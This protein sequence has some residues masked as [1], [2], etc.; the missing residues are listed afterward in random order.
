MTENKKIINEILEVISGF[1][2]GKY[3][4]ITQTTND[5]TLNAIIE[6]INNTGKVLK[7]L[8][9]NSPIGITETDSKGRLIKIN[10]AFANML[11]YSTSE[12]I[13]LD[14]SD[15]THPDDINKTNHFINNLSIEN[16]SPQKI[17]S[18]YLHKTGKIIWGT[19]TTQKIQITENKE[20]HYFMAVEEI[21]N[22]REKDD[23]LKMAEEQL[24]NS[25]V[26]R[27]IL[28]NAPSMI[29]V[30]DFNDNLNFTLLNK[31]GENLLG[32]KEIEILGK[33]NYDLY[34]KDDADYL[35]SQD[36]KV[37]KTK[38]NVLLD[39][40][41]VET[42][43]G[44]RMLATHKTAIFD[45]NGIPK[46]LIGISSDIT[47]EY[48]AKLEL[49]N[50]RLKSIHNAKLASLGEISAGIAHEI[51]NPLFIVT[52][53]VNLL[54]RYINDQQKFNDKIAGINKACNRINKIISSLKKFSGSGEKV[55]F[56]PVSLSQTINESF[57]LISAKA[58]DSNVRLTQ[59]VTTNSQILCDE[60][61]IEQVIINLISNS[62][63][64]IKDLED[65]WINVSLFERNSSVILQVT[66]SG[67]GIPK[68]VKEKLFDP[69][70]TTKKLGEGTGLGLSISKGILD[71][72]K[73]TISV[74]D[75]SKNTC[76]EIC[77]EKYYNIKAA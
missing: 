51:N 50:E 71:T 13:G 21:T 15:I 74:L 36:K 70:F 54:P 29:Y 10:H 8:F 19:T 16:S 42:P 48:Q 5:P 47:D 67:N 34:P 77:F 61:E 55:S 69:F 43:I 31:A 44:P 3:N 11:G 17:E 28:Q 45:N 40:A 25:E 52:G 35:T 58:S 72:H 59:N 38:K 7:I 33:N 68:N 75:D 63:D 53:T 20:E 66:D 56:I 12:M 41:M 57:A 46:F 4:T 22:L 6:E 9:E 62:I 64:A 60:I 2:S 1:K 23:I 26:L 27:A 76:F 18:R 39:Q 24:L 49:E 14:P 37:L 73:A 30:K 32:L 65:K